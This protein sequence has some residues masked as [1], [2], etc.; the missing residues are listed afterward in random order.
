MWATQADRLGYK[1]HVG[2]GKQIKLWEDVWFGNSPLATQY[3]DIYF[4]VNQ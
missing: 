2:N 3:L 4:I 1:W